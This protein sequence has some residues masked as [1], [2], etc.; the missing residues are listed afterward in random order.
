MLLLSLSSLPLSSLASTFIW[1]IP[2]HHNGAFV[3]LRSKYPRTSN[4]PLINSNLVRLFLQNVFSGVTS[5]PDVY[6]GDPL[7]LDLFVD[8]AIHVSH[9]DL[10]RQGGNYEEKT[11]SWISSETKKKYLTS[12]YEYILSAR[13]SHSKKQLVVMVESIPK[14]TEADIKL[15]ILSPQNT[16]IT[17]W[18]DDERYIGEVVDKELSSILK[19]NTDTI[20]YSKNTGTIFFMKWIEPNDEYKISLKYKISWPYDKKIQIY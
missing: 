3:R 5:I 20:M 18:F 16:I 9:V 1:C 17:E 4:I 2:S 12:T 11:T 19:S 10:L 8:K 13:S 6:P 15:E 14:S 7:T